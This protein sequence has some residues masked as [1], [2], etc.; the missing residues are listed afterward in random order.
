M[1]Q[2]VDRLPAD[3]RPGTFSIAAYDPSRETFGTAVATG[4]VA[5]GATCPYV[6]AD[7]AVLTQSFTRTEHGRDALARVADGEAIGD[8]GEAL[9]AADD[10]ASY[11]QVHGVDRSGTFVFTG[12]DCVSWCGHHAGD[13]HTVAGNMLAGGN[14]VDDVFE[15]FAET[16]PDDELGDRLLSALDAGDAAGGDKRGE[17]SAALLVHAPEP[18][19]AH[20]LRVDRADDPVSEL[21]SLYDHARTVQAG[22]REATDELVGENYPEA[23]LRTGI[24]Y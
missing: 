21:R 7:A 24:K 14:V 4:I 9:L 2:I 8:A 6:S 3:A 19:L 22:L 11:R 5:V 20:N 23:L 15:T 16:D 10:H 1:K 17:V 18:S 13:H 12:D